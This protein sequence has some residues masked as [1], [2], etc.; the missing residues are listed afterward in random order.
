[1]I[2]DEV[3]LRAYADSELEPRTSQLVEAAIAN[4]PVLTAQWQAL[5]ASRLSY[6]AAFEAQAL[7]PVPAELNRYVVDLISV[8]DAAQAAVAAAPSLATP[9]PATSTL[10]SADGRL[11]SRRVALFGV[12]W[13][14]AFAAGVLWRGWP[15][16][17]PAHLSQAASANAPWVNAIAQYHALYVRETLDQADDTPARLPGL[18]QGFSQ[19][20]GQGVQVPDLSAKGFAFKRVQR[21]GYEQKPLIQMVYL[22]ANGKPLALCFLPAS[23]ADEPVRSL[24]VAG[25]AA[26]FW[27][28]AGLAF[29]LVGDFSPPE[30]L[31]LGQW[32][33][34]R[35]GAATGLPKT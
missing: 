34:Q 12:G 25:L 32:V 24:P 6:D 21:L 29:V 9:R 35:M 4:S 19:A 17:T 18:L 13:A 22:P 10:P 11:T 15:N 30:A 14:A 2:V 20:L 33:A 1:M 8:A 7:P 3:L 31:D 23:G 27:Q 5:R 28:K 16:K 26:A